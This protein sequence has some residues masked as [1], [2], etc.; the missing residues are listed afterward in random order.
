MNEMTKIAAQPA[1]SDSVARLLKREPALFIDGQWVKSSHDARL[2]VFDPS[3][4]KEIASI[5]DASDADVD[6]A[7]RAARTAFDDGR[8]SGL[9]SYQ[10]ERTIA[11]LADL[12]EANIPVIAIDIPHP[13]ATYFGANNY[14][15]GLIGG[16]ALGRCRR[17]ID[18]DGH[19]ARQAGAEYA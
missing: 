17:K 1:Y 7:V 18:V 2:T 16:R 4:G 8:W 5:V 13:G 11:R 19:A 6:R 3:T 10:R 9:P 15:A 12:I 14:Q